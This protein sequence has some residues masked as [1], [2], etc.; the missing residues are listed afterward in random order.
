M[1]DCPDSVKDHPKYLEKHDTKEKCH[2]NQVDWIQ[3]EV[4]YIIFCNVML[5]IWIIVFRQEIWADSGCC[6]IDWFWSG[7]DGPADLAQGPVHSEP[8]EL[9]KSHL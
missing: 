9:L 2:E 7:D 3:C 6:H 1:T 8:V 5:C 4:L